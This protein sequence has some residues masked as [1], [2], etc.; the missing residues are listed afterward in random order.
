MESSLFPFAV[1]N[2]DGSATFYL[3]QDVSHNRWGSSLY[4]YKDSLKGPSVTVKQIRLA[5]FIK[6]YFFHKQIKL[7]KIDAEGT[8]YDIITDLLFEEFTY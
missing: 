3:D 1:S 7:M 6:K 2:M 8:E 4:A 5:N